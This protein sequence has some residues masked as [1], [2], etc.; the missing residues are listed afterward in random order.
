MLGTA[1]WLLRSGGMK[2]AHAY[3]KS[4]IKPKGCSLV[5]KNCSRN[6]K[7]R[8]KDC[9][10]VLMEYYGSLFMPN[11]N[12]NQDVDSAVRSPLLQL[13]MLPYQDR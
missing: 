13:T 6:I 7:H 12:H 9:A 1:M 3:F 8:E 4:I 2:K 11:P 5:L 10:G